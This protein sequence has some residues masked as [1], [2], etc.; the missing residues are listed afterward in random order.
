MSR[1]SSFLFAALAALVAVAAGGCTPTFIPANRVDSDGDGFFAPEKLTDLLEMPGSEM[2]EFKLDC[3]DTRDD[4]FPL[5]AELCDGVDNDCDRTDHEACLTRFGE[6]TESSDACL[7]LLNSCP[8]SLDGTER[9]DDG[10]GYTECGFTPETGEVSAA[11]RDCNDVAEAWGWYM[12]PGREEIC[13]M[14]PVL[15]LAPPCTED[16]ARPKVG[17]DDDCSGAPTPG[18]V[19]EDQDGYAAGCGLVDIDVGGV[20]L[21]EDCDDAAGGAGRNPG[22]GE[23][24]GACET[25]EVGCVAGET[26][27]ATNCTDDDVPREPWYPNCDYDG[28][29]S[30]AEQ[31]WLLLCDN[32]TP[33]GY[34][35]N[36]ETEDP[37]PCLYNGVEAPAGRNW[38]DSNLSPNLNTDCDDGDNRFNGLDVDGDGHSTCD[39]D[40]YLNL[41]SADGEPYAYPGACEMCDMID[42][43][44]DGDVD[45]GYDQDNDGA[46]LYYSLA[47]LGGCADNP[48]GAV[49]ECEVELPAGY[50]NAHDPDDIDCDDTDATL[51]VQ[52]LDGDNVSTCEGDC[53]DG[54]S[55]IDNTDNDG[56]G[57]TTCM[58]PPDCDDNDPTRF[59]EDIDGDL[60]TS[61]QGDC[62]DTLTDDLTTANV[63]EAAISASVYPGNGVQCDGWLDTD[64]DGV[65]D[66]LEDDADGDGSTECGGV[67][68]GD[69]G[70]CD[71]TNPALNG[72]DLDGDGW[73][74]CDGDCKDD[75]AVYP[76]ASDVFPGAPNLC[77][78]E[79]DNDCN[80]IPDPNEADA[81][82]DGNT[83]CV[84]LTATDPPPPDCNDFDSTVESLDVD[85]DGFSTCEG[86]CDDSDDTITP[87]TDA[88]NDGWALC[89]QAGVPGDCDDSDELMTWSDVDGD[90]Q[91][92]CDASD[93]DCD[94]FDASLNQNDV[95]GDLQTSCEGDCN[96]DEPAMLLTGSAETAMDGLDNDCDGTAD[97]GLVVAGALAIIEIL[98]AADPTTG[99][100]YAEYVEV[101]N[102][103][104]QPIDLRGWQVDVEDDGL[105]TTTTFEFL[106]GLDE[107]PKLIGAGERAVLARPTNYLAFAADVADIYWS[108]ASFSDIGGA[109][110]LYAVDVVPP[111]DELSW[112]ATGCDSACDTDSPNYSG[113]PY[114]R[115]GYAMGLK[116][117]FVSTTPHLSND[118]PL[119]WCEE[120]PLVPGSTVDHGTPGEPMTGQGECG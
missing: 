105:G 33:L 57:Y 111:V 64:C 101:I 1:S 70:D 5:A 53:N 99:D 16:P 91:S 110:S 28:D 50:G 56:D 54:N 18:E 71:D 108:A 4:V 68:T 55:T 112:D 118:Q 29:G 37:V 100:G 113:P 90:G 104:G 59:P 92:T 11:D 80:G 115:P 61:C 9:D 34:Q 30:A 52:D 106:Q 65:T 69:E 15:G 77:D 38:I 45:E 12:N 74:T 89:P 58:V 31:D 48:Y 23:A 94:D 26:Y 87:E 109:I 35:T 43:D 83:I 32:E 7:E 120:G 119:N 49:K 42:N 10:D 96:D 75:P 85:G 62:L 114:W 97:E 17:L 88:D 60:Y 3:D 73:T 76:L 107:P 116:E 93:A 78:G 79:P 21:E 84:N 39:G 95:D 6:C 117:S 13:A 66:P 40:H 14:R 51:N 86:D 41:V 19:D 103:S 44:L 20:P 8:E 46:Y 72:L 47:D 102:T 63:D 27:T 25:I 2:A 82:G 98:I 81:D 22:I 67:L 36:P 24:G